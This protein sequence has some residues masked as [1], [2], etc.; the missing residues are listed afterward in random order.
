MNF[1][2]LKLLL[3][4]CEVN[5]KFMLSSLCSPGGFECH[6]RII[7]PSMH[8]TNLVLSLIILR[9]ILKR[10]RL[11]DEEKRNLSDAFLIRLTL[12]F[13]FC[14][15]LLCRL[16]V[17]IILFVHSNNFC[18]LLKDFLTPASEIDPNLCFIDRL[19]CSMFVNLHFHFGF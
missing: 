18:V 13:H 5:F 7:S 10:K 16:K 14:A 11:I 8:V 2:S 19:P 17:L 4:L 12:G 3:C 9:V 1:K 6:P 15:S